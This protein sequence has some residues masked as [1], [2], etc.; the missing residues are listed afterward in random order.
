V[1]SLDARHAG[2]LRGIV[3]ERP[4]G[5]AVDAGAT[6]EQTRAALASL[7]IDLGGTP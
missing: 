4:A 5:Q 1:I 3:G 7:R 6:E 2:W